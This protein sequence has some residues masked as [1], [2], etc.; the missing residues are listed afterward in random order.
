MSRSLDLPL[1]AQLW[2]TE[3]AP[4]L[5]FTEQGAKPEIQG[6]L[7][8]QGVEVIELLQLT[9]AQVM[10]N[11]YDR[12]FLSVFWECGGTLAAKAIADGSIQKVL[13][14]IA[15][16]IIGGGA[17]APS[18]VGDLGLTQMTEAIEL[19]QVSWEAIGMDLLMEGYLGD[20]GF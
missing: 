12:G 15:P 1:N 18:P 4:T 2:Q 14:L 5:V 19:N 6:I 11:L 13:A 9:P 16:K 7:K 10:T 3:I 20:F 17:I 8:A